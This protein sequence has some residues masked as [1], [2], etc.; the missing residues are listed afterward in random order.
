MVR[1]FRADLHIHS[2]LSP[3]GE[4]EMTPRSIVRVSLEKKLD[5]IAVCDHNSAENVRGVRQAAQD[6]DLTILAGMEVTTAEEVHLLGFFDE[7]AQAISFQDI[8]YAHLL[9]GQNDEDLFGMQVVANAE[10]EVEAIV[11]KLLIGGT[12]LSLE[13]TI[14]HIHRLGGLAVASHIDRESFSFVG[15]L[16]MI[17]EDLDLDAVEI[18]PL[19]QIGEVKNIPGAE[20]FPAIA[21]SDA[22]RLEDIGCVT[23][24]FLMDEASVHAMRKAFRC[25]DG[26][27]IL[28]A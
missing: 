2:C 7:E 18:S 6:T 4:L 12:T 28:D 19:N 22:H 3:C 5:M 24:S 26:C 23:T 14:A 10:D 1:P 8:V 20:R 27:R 17:P 13:E 21:S 11:D 15:Q 25:I 9:P 16:G